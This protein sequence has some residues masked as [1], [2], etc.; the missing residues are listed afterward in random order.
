MML[1]DSEVSEARCSIVISGPGGID[2]YA[3]LPECHRA[4]LNVAAIRDEN[5]MRAKSAAF[6]YCILTPVNEPART[7]MPAEGSW[8]PDVIKGSMGDLICPLDGIIHTFT[9]LVD[10]A[11]RAMAAVEAVY[12][13]S[14][15]EGIAVCY[16]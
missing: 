13:S 5:E 2:C 4:G 7:S 1:I 10:G 12:E 11:N 15:S 6:E 14:T 8:L 16:D 9:T 3:H